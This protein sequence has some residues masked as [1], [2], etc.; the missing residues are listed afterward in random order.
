M[1]NKRYASQAGWARLARMLAPGGEAW[2]A[3]HHSLGAAYHDR[4]EG[5]ATEN[6]DAAAKHLNQAL[7]VYEVWCRAISHTH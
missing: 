5:N 7:G 2:A 3:V 6:I 4:F 1:W